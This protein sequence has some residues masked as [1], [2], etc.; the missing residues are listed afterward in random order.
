MSDNLDSSNTPLQPSSPETAPADVAA[1][2]LP[3]RQPWKDEF[4]IKKLLDEQTTDRCT[5]GKVRLQKERDQHVSMG[6]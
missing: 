6:G 3:L 5:T 2:L 1:K 4:D